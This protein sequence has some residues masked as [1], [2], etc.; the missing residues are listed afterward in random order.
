MREIVELGRLDDAADLGVVDAVGGT[1]AI[2]EMIQRGQRDF[3][4]LSAAWNAVFIEH[5]RALSVYA[6]QG[7]PPGASAAG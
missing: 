3:V 5:E 2:D 1:A 6:K 7:V 4:Q